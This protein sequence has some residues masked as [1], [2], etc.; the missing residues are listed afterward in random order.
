MG[1][2]AHFSYPE[3][4]GKEFSHSLRPCSA[5][6]STLP[7]NTL[8]GH[9]LPLLHIEA[10]VVDRPSTRGR[11]WVLYDQKLSP[12]LGMELIFIVR[13]GMEDHCARPI[14]AAADPKCSLEDIPDLREIVVV[15]RMMRTR[16]KA[17]NA[18]VAMTSNVKSW[19]QLFSGHHNIF[20]PRCIGRG[21]ASQIRRLIRLLSVG[22][23]PPDWPPSGACLSLGAS[24]LSSP[25]HAAE[26]DTTPGRRLVRGP[27]A[28]LLSSLLRR[29]LSWS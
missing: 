13:I 20:C 4:A 22:W 16:L 10:I 18:R 27:L 8:C 5:P 15:Q 9:R 24:V 7:V 2:G 29:M 23:R 3:A 6:T 11:S 17:Q 19:E 12:S 25:R 21:G 26:G 14:L 28:I 1:F